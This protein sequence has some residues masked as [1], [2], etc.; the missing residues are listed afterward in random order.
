[1]SATDS[2][3]TPK[4]RVLIADDFHETR[5]SVRLMLSMNPDVIVVAIAKDGREAVELAREHHPDIVVMDI[6]M[7]QVDGLAAFKQISDIHPDTGCILISAQKEI[8]FLN[9][10]ITLGVQ[11]YLCKPFTIEELNDAINRVGIQVRQ[12]RPSL[13]NASRLHKQSESYLE[14]LAK[15]YAKEKRTDDLALG[16]FEQLAENPAC[17]LRWLRTLAMLYIIRQEWD[18]LKALAERLEKS[19]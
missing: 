13:E 16:V 9:A 18:K 10:A 17:E 2:S 11:E 4:L 1:M 14:K 5:R 15:E 12:K 8:Q 6:N 7:P 19:L 3:S